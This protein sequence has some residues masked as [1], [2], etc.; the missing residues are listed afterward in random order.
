MRK[1]RRARR[2]RPIQEYCHQLCCML[3]E[4]VF[5]VFVIAI[6]ISGAVIEKLL[7]LNIDY[8]CDSD[9]DSEFWKLRRM[10]P[11]LIM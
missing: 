5:I 3:S 6:A 11:N 7:E 4:I 9:N 1:Y 2:P 10:P 8:D